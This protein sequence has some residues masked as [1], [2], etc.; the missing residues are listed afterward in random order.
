MKYGR[1]IL[2]AGNIGDQAQLIGLDALYAAMDIP[3]ED[4]VDL[5]FKE[6]HTYRGEK[7]ICPIYG[8]WIS[9]QSTLEYARYHHPSPDII[10]V[11]LGIFAA[12]FGIPDTLSKFLKKNG[13]LPILCRDE[14]SVNVFRKKG[15]RA[16]FWG[17]LS[18]L[19]Q[20]TGLSLS[21][22][23]TVFYEA[24]ALSH[25]HINSLIPELIRHHAKVLL[26]GQDIMDD[27]QHMMLSAKDRNAHEYALMSQREALLAERAEYVIAT[28]MHLALPCIAMGIPVLY[29]SPDARS[30]RNILPHSLYK[31]C[32]PEEFDASRL[33]PVPDIHVVKVRLLETARNLL[34]CAR[35]REMENEALIDAV[36]D[37]QKIYFMQKK[38]H[39]KVPIPNRGYIG[40]AYDRPQCLTMEDFFYHLTGK[41]PQETNLI[42][43]GAG[44][45]GRLTLNNMYLLV[46]K[47]R[48]FTFID[49]DETKHTKKFAGYFSVSSPE[50]LQNYNTDNLVIFITMSGNTGG[51]A[52]SAARYLEEHYS[53]VNGINF[54][55]YEY[56][57]MSLFQFCF[58]YPA[59]VPSFYPPNQ[60]MI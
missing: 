1:M 39:Y 27:A 5:T 28:S 53:L 57:V 34:V 41:I 58:G 24:P 51:K 19:T 2:G 35:N 12:D 38:E 31:Y 20:A 47:C 21:K 16:V 15:Y 37:V 49:G 52:E 9:K 60:R 4:L 14:F 11:F 8:C 6:L 18:L 59:Y 17:C 46:K 33:P 45:F 3:K 26:P 56:I 36:V 25:G 30:P 50:I 32:N 22:K 40:I 48:T 42:F 55:W 23:D 10:P 54:Y 7:I 13:D 29:L 44:G 43:Y